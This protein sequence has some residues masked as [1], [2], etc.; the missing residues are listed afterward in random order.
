MIRFNLEM[1]TRD[2]L[3]VPCLTTDYWTTL[4]DVPGRRLAEAFAR[5]RANASRPGLPHVSTLQPARR[6][7]VE[8]DNVRRCF[9]YARERLGL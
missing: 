8:E 7:E 1:I 5:V 2:P 6:L 4:E 3:R 9:R